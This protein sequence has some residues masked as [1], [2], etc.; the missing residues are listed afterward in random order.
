MA[1]ASRGIGEGRFSEDEAALVDCFGSLLWT[2][3]ESDADDDF[4]WEEDSS[5]GG[6]GGGSGG[7]R[8]AMALWIRE[9]VGGRGE[10]EE[11]EVDLKMGEELEADWKVSKVRGVA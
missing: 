9:K 3:F 4:L 5:E 7:A 8:G 1:W 11:L 6:G 2:L 10:L